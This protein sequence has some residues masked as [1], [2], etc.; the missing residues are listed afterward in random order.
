[1]MLMALLSMP[2]DALTTELRIENQLD[3]NF[4]NNYKLTFSDNS[5]FI[6]GKAIKPF[7]SIL[8]NERDLSGVLYTNIIKDNKY[9]Y[10]FGFDINSL[11]LS[12]IDYVGFDLK[13]FKQL[14]SISFTDGIIRIIFDDLIGKGDMQIIND[15]RLILYEPTS[16][17]IDPTVELLPNATNKAYKN[18]T[19]LNTNC[20]VQS[21]IATAEFTSSNYN[22]VNTSNNARYSHS[23]ITTIA[24]GTK[25]NQYIFTFNTSAISKPSI[26]QIILSHEGYYSSP[27]HDSYSDLWYYN[28]YQF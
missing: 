12:N 9:N 28:A 6:D 21:W 16:L 25:C 19:S 23:A 18:L 22:N 4:T 27:I 26:T 2:I 13:G 1:M 11:S 7:I 3:Y 17:L 20:G 24:G 10:E 15:S 8:N 5:F 14:D